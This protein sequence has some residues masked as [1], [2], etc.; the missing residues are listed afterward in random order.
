MHQN[1]HS[2]CQG[3]QLPGAAWQCGSG[4][5]GVYAPWGSSPA[6]EEELEPERGPAF[7]AENLGSPE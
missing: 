4:Q 3:L 6:H 1:F 7:T 5:E 2:S